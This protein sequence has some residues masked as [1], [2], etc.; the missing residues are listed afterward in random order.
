MLD[1]LELKGK[2]EIRIWVFL[3][4]LVIKGYGGIFLVCDYCYESFNYFFSFVILFKIRFLWGGRG[5]GL[6]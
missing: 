6:V 2:L 5:E 1:R 4:N 3:E